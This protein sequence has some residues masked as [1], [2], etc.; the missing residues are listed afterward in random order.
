MFA[1]NQT[2]THDSE[3]EVL[4]L[5]RERTNRTKS[6]TKTSVA[7]RSRYNDLK[8]A[9]AACGGAGTYGF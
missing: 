5:Y 4:E 2:V 3:P 1:G 8:V 7:V 6:R 9:A